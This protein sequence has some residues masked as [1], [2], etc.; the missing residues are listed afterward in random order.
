MT[1]KQITAKPEHWTVGATTKDGWT[2]VRV[3]Q[4]FAVLKKASEGKPTE[5]AAETIEGKRLAAKSSGD[6]GEKGRTYRDAQQAKGVTVK[7]TRTAPAKKAAAPAKKAA[8]KKAAPAKKAATKKASPA[9]A[10]TRRV[11]A[12]DKVNKRA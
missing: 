10:T 6:A 5:W 9:K 1:E 7:R 3:R 12:R 4:F 11:T 8:A 2:V